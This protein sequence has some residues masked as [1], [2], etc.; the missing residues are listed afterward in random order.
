MHVCEDYS[1]TLD[2]FSYMIL[3][4]WVSKA[5]HPQTRTRTR[6]VTKKHW[7]S[8]TCHRQIRTP[9]GVAKK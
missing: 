2:F 7:V 4:R 6:V 1:D 9:T 8:K 5:R 3:F